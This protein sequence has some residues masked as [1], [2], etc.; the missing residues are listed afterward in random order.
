[1]HNMNF[2]LYVL[3]IVSVHVCLCVCICVYVCLCVCV[4]VCLC[5]CVCLCL[6]LCLSVSV[7]VSV[8]V[9]MR[10]DGCVVRE[11]LRFI[12]L[13]LLIVNTKEINKILKIL[14]SFSNNPFIIIHFLFQFSMTKRVWLILC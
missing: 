9:Y 6:C 5:V 10:E 3:D 2:P 11:D 8:S 7:S 12:I 13:V 1:M 14:E 4:Y